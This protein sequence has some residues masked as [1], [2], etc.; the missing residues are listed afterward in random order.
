MMLVSHLNV[1]IFYIIQPLTEVETWLAIAKHVAAEDDRPL[2]Q[3]RSCGV[4]TTDFRRSS[5]MVRLSK[6]VG[7]EQKKLTCSTF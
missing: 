1:K 2:K 4:S 3:G 6:W 5:Q 7:V